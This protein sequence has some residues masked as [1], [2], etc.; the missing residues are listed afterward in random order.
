[1]CLLCVPVKMNT[2]CVLLFIKPS[3]GGFVKQLFNKSSVKL[4]LSGESQIINVIDRKSTLRHV[5]INT[6]HCTCQMLLL[7]VV[8]CTNKQQ[9]NDYNHSTLLATKRHSQ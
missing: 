8:Q 6:L 1:M 3:Y 4:T 9:V 5:Y 2:C 7:Y